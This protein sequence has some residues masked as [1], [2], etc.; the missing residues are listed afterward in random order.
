MP[1]YSKIKPENFESAFLDM[2]HT[3]CSEDIQHMLNRQN[4]SKYLKSDCL[5]LGL[6]SAASLR[7]LEVFDTLFDYIKKEKIEI[8]NIILEKLFNSVC[9]SQSPERIE[10][11]DA[12]FD[13]SKYMMVNSSTIDRIT[14]INNDMNVYFA[15]IY[16]IYNTHKE[17]LLNSFNEHGLIV[18]TRDGNNELVNYLLSTPVEIPKKL[19]EASFIVAC[20]NEKFDT[21]MI[22]YSK[23]GNIKNSEF[24]KDFVRTFSDENDKKLHFV[25]KLILKEE[26]DNQLIV[27]NPINKKNKL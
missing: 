3:G 19:L 4:A 10:K 16:G 22:L 25:C 20:H 6:I 13:F 12:I 1:I 17:E 14:I 15:S 27:N 9:A 26:M 18:A 8:P 24:I 21:A 2:I 5:Y 11:L 23:L 7:S